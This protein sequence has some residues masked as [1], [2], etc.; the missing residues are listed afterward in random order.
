MRRLH[1]GQVIRVDKTAAG[2]FVISRDAEDARARADQV[3]RRSPDPLLH[4]LES[5]VIGT[6]KHA[7]QIM[8]DDMI[9]MGCVAVSVAVAV[10]VAT[11]E[12]SAFRVVVGVVFALYVPGR[13]IVSNWPRLAARSNVAA[14]VLFSLSIL[15]LLATLTLWAGYWHPLGLLEIEC[16]AAGVALF[17]ALLRRRRADQAGAAVPAGTE[18]ATELHDLDS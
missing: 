3:F 13:S 7:A 15:T 4:R 9:D 6:D 14:S 18:S 11:G 8:R 1:C 10:A 2:K 17:T 16:V 12:R 5:S